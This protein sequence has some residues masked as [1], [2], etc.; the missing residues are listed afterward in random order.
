MSVEW[1]P[2]TDDV[3]VTG[4]NLYVDGAPAGTTTGT[5]FT[6]SGLG[7][8]TGYQLGVEAVDASGNTSPRAVSIG[9]TAPCGPSAGLVAAYAFDEG[10]G[11]VAVDASG[12]GHAGTL[13][14][15]TWTTGRYGG[16]LSFNGTS[17]YVGL[18]SLGTFYNTAF[19]LEA[20][21][22]KQ[23]AK[24]DVAIVGSWA[25]SGPMLW[26]D[27]L[28]SHY[29]L[30]LGSNGISGYLD[31]GHNPIAGQ[32]QHLAATYDGT[33]ARYYI[34]GTEVASRAVTGSVGSSNIWRIGAYGTTPGGFFDGVIDDVRIYNRALTAGDVRFDLAQ[35]VTSFGPPPDTTPPSAPGNAHRNR[36][37][38][39]GDAGLG[40]RDRQRRRHPLRR[41]PVDD[42]R[43][44][45]VER[46][47]D[48]ATHGHRVHGREP[49]SWNLLL[50][51]RSRGRRR[52]R[53]SRLERGEHHPRRGH[54]QA[55]RVDHR[56]GGR[57]DR[58]VDC[59]RQCQR[60]RQ[61]RRRRSAV[62]AGRRKSGGGGHDCPVLDRL[63][64]ARGTERVAFPE[65]RRP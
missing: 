18:G 39:A 54:H 48:R 53:G 60:K 15:A 50:P 32:W 17:A 27:H 44:H 31:S 33:T 55:E 36:R 45:G 34:D 62:Q 13:A 3:G 63:G 10:S 56:A 22:Q 28:A 8:S 46:K 1:T 43:L 4:Y 24:N 42:Q 38:R 52:Q 41:V 20:W 59:H 64:H 12:N 35:Q 26:V 23:T 9:A 19:T 51:G 2:S 49:R 6:F 57:V 21:V 65:R 5:T 11:G 14:G 25:G 61:C 16:G 37:N 40:C 58:A 47:P 7:C 30:T 29:Q